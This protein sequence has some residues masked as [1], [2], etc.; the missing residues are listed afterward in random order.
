M[1]PDLKLECFENGENE[2]RGNKNKN[3]DNEEENCPNQAFNQFAPFGVED[4]VWKRDKYRD[5]K[6][7]TI[8][9]K[10]F[11]KATEK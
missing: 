9:R 11:L 7:K 8:K 6:I 1:L 5:R 3:R 2:I 10:I 4:D